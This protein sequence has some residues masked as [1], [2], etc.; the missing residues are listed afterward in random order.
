[1]RYEELETVL[2]PEG[3]EPVKDE[4]DEEVFEIITEVTKWED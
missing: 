1:M 3:S 4:I 2:I